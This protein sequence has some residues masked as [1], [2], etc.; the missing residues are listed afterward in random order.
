[1]KYRRWAALAALLAWNSSAGA[2]AARTGC[3]ALNLGFG[4]KSAGW[5]HQPLS[6]FKRDTVYTVAQQ[7]GRAVLSG[8]AQRSASLYVAR[9]KPAASM[10]AAISWSWKTDA[11]VPGAD[12]RDRNREDAPLRVIVSFDGDHASLPPA[13]RTLLRKFGL[14]FAT[15]MYIWSDH[16]AA[17]SIIASAH[18]ARVQMLVVASGATALGRWQSARRS[19]ADDYRRAYGADPG[20]MV[21]VAVMTDTDNTGETAVGHYA[22][23]RLECAAK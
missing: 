9:V 21:S 4:Q 18:T 12:N 22:D 1:M 10:P 17:E 6:I 3:Q 11:L 23:I 14:P 5:V 16:V 20:P 7:G 15:L 8:S 2:A 13:E 19:I